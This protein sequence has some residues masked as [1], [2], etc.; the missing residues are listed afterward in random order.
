MIQVFQRCSKCSCVLLSVVSFQDL[1]YYS[2]SFG[3]VS[4]RTSS[5]FLGQKLIWTV[6]ELCGVLAKPLKAEYG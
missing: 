5:S 3:S 1:L 4:M 2:F 6:C